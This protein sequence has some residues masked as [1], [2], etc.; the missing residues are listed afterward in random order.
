MQVDMKNSLAAVGPIVENNPVT[1]LKA[2]FF[3]QF[4]AN[5]DDLSNQPV[6]LCIQC[7]EI[8]D[9]F[10]RNYQKMGRRLR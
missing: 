9:M 1:A 7:V 6:I 10:F 5:T 2:L 8:T 4:P 3:R